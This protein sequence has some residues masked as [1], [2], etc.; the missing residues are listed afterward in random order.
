MRAKCEC[1]I[2]K[3]TVS[4]LVELNSSLP[5]EYWASYSCQELHINRYDMK[6]DKTNTQHKSLQYWTNITGE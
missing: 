1:H 4:S 3:G 6:H 2:S 5:K